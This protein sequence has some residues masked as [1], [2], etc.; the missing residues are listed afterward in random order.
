[1]ATMY[2]PFLND[3]NMIKP[4]ILMDEEK[5]QVWKQNLVTADQAAIIRDT[6]RNVVTEG[7]AGY[8]KNAPFPISGKTGTA[9]LKLTLDEENGAENGWFVAYPS[10]D[11]DMIIAMMMEKVQDKGSSA[12]VVEKVTDLM[13]KLK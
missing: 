6:L 10:E 13:E 8:A 7:T 1:M 9:E 3:G 11:Q 5:S 2:T 4:V 12:L